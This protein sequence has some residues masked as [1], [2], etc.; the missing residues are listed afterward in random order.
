MAHRKHAKHK[1]A[2]QMQPPKGIG[3]RTA[4]E[5]DA[6]TPPDKPLKGTN[7]RM[8]PEEVAAIMSRVIGSIPLPSEPAPKPG[9]DDHGWEHRS[10]SSISG[11]RAPGMVTYGEIS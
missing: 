8:T 6:L 9:D 3:D 4:E 7:H 2:K 10:R 1:Q 11:D 5:L